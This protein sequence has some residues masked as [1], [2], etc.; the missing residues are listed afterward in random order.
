MEPMRGVATTGAGIG[1]AGQCSFVRGGASG[2]RE[3]P[4]VCFFFP[5]FITSNLN[6]LGPVVEVVGIVYIHIRIS[7]TYAVRSSREEHRCLAGCGV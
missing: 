4:A 2:E 5:K 7:H 6:F 1:L 3:T